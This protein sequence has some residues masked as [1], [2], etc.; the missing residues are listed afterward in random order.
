VFSSD[1]ALPQLW[2]KTSISGAFLGRFRETLWRQIVP[3]SAFPTPGRTPTTT[4]AFGSV[5]GHDICDEI[6]LCDAA[7]IMVSRYQTGKRSASPEA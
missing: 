3:T 6:I 1:E 2:R 7:T 5:A 4:A